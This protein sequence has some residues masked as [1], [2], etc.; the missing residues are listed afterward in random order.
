MKTKT[1]EKSGFFK[2]PRAVTMLG[3]LVA[4]FLAA[5]DQTIVSTAMP[6]IVRE[7]NGLS[8]LSWVFTAYMLASTVTVP[9][10]GKLSDIY[11]RRPFFLGGIVIFLVGSTLSGFSQT[12][13]ALIFF[14][15]IQGVGAGAIMVNAFSIIA[16]LFTP[17]ERGKWQGVIGATFGV[18]S[19]AGPLLGGVITDF[20][21]W[22]WVFF[23]NIPVGI[24]AFLVAFVV[25]PRMARGQKKV[26]IDYFGAL[27]LAGALIPFLLAL[28]WGGSE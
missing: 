13:G 4:M 16:D 18:A 2:D 26:S 19:I 12:M 28:V 9:I 15:A 5:L 23:V 7:L 10:Y 17:L 27:S 21:T 8:H 11:G 6:N 22:R 20:F 14:R 1:S 24:L 25:M 3:V